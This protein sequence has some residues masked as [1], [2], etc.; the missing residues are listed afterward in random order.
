MAPEL[1]ETMRTLN[2]ITMNDTGQS[3]QYFIEAATRL[4]AKKIQGEYLQEIKGIAA[5]ATSAGTPLTW[6]DVLALNGEMELTGY[7][8]PG[9]L[10]GDYS[11]GLD[12]THCSAFIATGSYT[13]DGKVVMAHNDWDHY[14]TGQF[15]NLIV[16]VKPSSGH[17]LIMQ[18]FPGCIASMT[19]YFATDAGLMGTETTIGNYDSYD[20]TKMPEFYRMRKATQYADTLDEWVK[21]MQAS[22]NGGYANSWLLA[23]ADSGEIM[24]FEQGLKYQSVERTTDGFFVG[25]NG[26]TD[27]KIRNLECGG[28]SNFYDIR[29]ATGARRVRLTQLMNEN[30]GSHRHRGGEDHP[31]RPLRRLPR[32]GRQPLLADRRRPLRARPLPVLAGAPALL[33]AGRRRRQGHG[34]RHGQGAELRGAL[35]QLERHAVRRRGVLPGAPAVELPRRVREGQAHAA[36][37]GVQGGRAAERG[38]Q[39]PPPEPAGGGG[40]SAS[41]SPAATAGRLRRTTFLPPSRRLC[42]ARWACAPALPVAAPVALRAPSTTLPAW[43]R[44]GRGALRDLLQPALRLRADLAS[45]GARLLDHHRRRLASLG[46]RLG[47]DALALG[48]G[49]QAGLVPAGRR[50]PHHVG[51]AE[52]HRGLRHD[53]VAGHQTDQGPGDLPPHHGA[54]DH[55]GDLEHALL[56]LR[57]RPAGQGQPVDH[58][59]LVLGEDE[60]VGGRDGDAEDGH[61]R[62]HARGQGE[63]RVRHRDL[64]RQVGGEQGPEA[65]QAPRGGQ[66]ASAGSASSTAPPTM[67]AAAADCGSTS[68]AAPRSRYTDHGVG[69]PAASPKSS[70]TWL[71]RGAVERR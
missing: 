23:D 1:A 51:A 18:S 65:G 52:G 58:Q 37:D 62:R 70:T 67:A 60:G 26:A 45:G 4:W 57:R 28:D 12:K 20:P 42:A 29:T 59:R 22:N 63:G 2:Y 54:A 39:S 11:D 46:G 30:R 31:R 55:G 50:Q 64:A 69:A 25:F 34:Q 5:G 53:A 43:A 47:H 66:P 15:A 61:Q 40:W 9:I 36:L 49:E 24:R 71:G 48:V 16:D 68:V 41:P 13:K 21:Y 35:G 17:R 27:P 10:S 7:W 8:Y 19:D 38:R 14:V 3:W 56:E 33:T 6:Q 32:E 44:G